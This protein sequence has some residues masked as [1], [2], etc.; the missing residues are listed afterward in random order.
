MALR[1]VRRVDEQLESRD[2][3]GR[4]DVIDALA[5]G[6]RILRALEPRWR[7]VMRGSDAA[8][9]LSRLNEQI[10]NR[11]Q[12]LSASEPAEVIVV[13]AG[14]PSVFMSEGW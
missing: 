9:A 12:Q 1:A 10:R 3:V 5:S 2:L 4:E 14:R 13:T 11:T 8:I 7:E 6:H